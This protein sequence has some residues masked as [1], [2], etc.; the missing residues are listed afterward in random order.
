MY[1]F[2]VILFSS[3]LLSSSL[4]SVDGHGGGKKTV[5]IFNYQYD[6][7]TFDS[8]NAKIVNYLS[9]QSQYYPSTNGY[10]GWNQLSNLLTGQRPPS[11]ANN[12]YYA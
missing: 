12:E 1:K 7:K 10:N 2:T 5:Y 9:G 8:N 4:K 6:P 3:L 11:A